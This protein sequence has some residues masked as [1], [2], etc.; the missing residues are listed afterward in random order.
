[1]TKQAE[2]VATHSIPLLPLRDIVVFPHMVLPL[3]VGRER[4]IN[5][6][7]EALL[8]NKEI[9][10]ASQQKAKTNHPRP[11]DIYQVGTLGSIIQLLKFFRRIAGDCTQVIE[12]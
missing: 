4:S 2:P 6:L 10:L 8:S 3:F 1:M 7:E 9:L 12:P 11:E 5:A